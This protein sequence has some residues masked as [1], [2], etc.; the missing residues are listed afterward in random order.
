MKQYRYIDDLVLAAFWTLG[1]AA[2]VAALLR[3]GGGW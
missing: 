2:I 3:I 1:A